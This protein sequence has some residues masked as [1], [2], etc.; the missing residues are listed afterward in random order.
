[1]DELLGSAQCVFFDF[2]GPVCSLFHGRSSEDIARQLSLGLAVSLPPSKDPQD[3]VVS[4]FHR[5]RLVADGTAH[6]IEG[7][8]TEEECA[9][10]LSAY[11]T[12]YADTLIRTLTA[13]GRQL[14]ITT[15]NSEWA[16]ERYLGRRSLDRLFTG[17]IHG[18]TAEHPL[19]IKPDPDCLLRAL[20]S[21]GAAVGETVMIGDAAQDLAA[22]RAAGVGFIGYARNGRKYRELA[23]AGVDDRH[24]VRSLA[25][26]LLAVDP[27]AHV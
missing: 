12:P 16:V 3:I 26:V 5:P 20:K 8:L 19:R 11:P 18:R 10:A 9:A 23:A 14:A 24:I 13:M 7:A 22:A 2:D 15:N 4:A 25:D 27:G 1:M 17:N 21:T 6:R